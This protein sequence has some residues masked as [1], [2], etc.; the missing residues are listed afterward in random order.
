MPEDNTVFDVS[1]PNKVGASPNSRPVII[2]HHP[3]MPDPMFRKFRSAA[4]K[5]E[6]VES[7]NIVHPNNLSGSALSADSLTE[8]EPLGP[9]A[10]MEGEPLQSP[11]FE[12]G[13]SSSASK[14]NRKQP[15]YMPISSLTGIASNIPAGSLVDEDALDSSPKSSSREVMAR[16]DT[17]L[18]LPAGKDSN[19]R[20]HLWWLMIPLVV[21]I[22]LYLALDSGLLP[23]SINLPL[24]VFKQD[25][26]SAI[27]TAPATNNSTPVVP[28]GFS[29]YNLAGT[30]LSF[31]S[32]TPWGAPTAAPDPGFSKRGGT[33]V[34]DGKFAYIVDFPGNKDVQMAFTS[35]KYLPAARGAQ[36]YDLLGWCIGTNDGN[37]YQSVL[38][39]NTASGVDTPATITCD[40]G[41]LLGVI[42]LDSDT[43]V[44]LGTKTTDGKI[45]GDLYT[46]NLKDK[47]LVVVRV[48]DATT[49]NAELIKTLLGS[50]QSSSI[51]Q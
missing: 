50:I 4:A 31:A 40:Q 26:Q 13:S 51:G 46:K 29:K 25:K 1:K 18:D 5:S 36:Y 49:K 19:N 33:N 10:V 47:N 41:P 23:G 24:H 3:T 12:V 30:N 21:I 15:P 42:K 16:D 22:G 2:G 44:Q 45:F 6:H 14:P 17:P 37:Y 39:Y 7:K 35:S 32:P 48:R 43:I 28:S 8:S 11:P 34:S 9:V 38:R 20:F 27:S